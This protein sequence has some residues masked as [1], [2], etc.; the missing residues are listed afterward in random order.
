MKIPASE[1]QVK[2]K[3]K[4]I[5]TYRK[6]KKLSIQK[7]QRNYQYKAAKLTILSSAER[8]AVETMDGSHFQI[9]EAK[10]FREEPSKVNNLASEIRSL[11]LTRSSR[12]RKQQEGLR[13]PL[14]RN[15]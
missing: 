3:K 13:A 5:N 1:K 14:V 9:E 15:F 11:V 4:I 6:P 10:P 12:S 2:R 8:S 7:T